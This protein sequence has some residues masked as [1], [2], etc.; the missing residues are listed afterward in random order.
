MWKRLQQVDSEKVWSIRPRLRAVLIEDVR[1]RLPRWWLERGAAET[2]MGGIATAFDPD[3]L[4]IG[5]TCR[6]P[7][8]RLLM[9]M[10]PCRAGMMLMENG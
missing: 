6:V 1:G 8:Y 3:V 4:T 2:E 7:T 10:L 9:L 5:F